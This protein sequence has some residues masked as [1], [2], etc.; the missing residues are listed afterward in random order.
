[1]LSFV[2][3]NRVRGAVLVL[4]C[5]TIAGCAV[6][7]RVQMTRAGGV[8][9][10]RVRIDYK[11]RES[12]ARFVSFGDD[13]IRLVGVPE[14]REKYS[15]ADDWFV[16]DLTVE[17]PADESRLDLARATLSIHEKDSTLPGGEPKIIRMTFD[18]P[19]QQLD[20]LL[21]DLAHSGFFESQSRPN[22]GV[23][24]KVAIDRGHNAKPWTREARLDDLA[25]RVYHEGTVTPVEQND[26]LQSRGCW[27]PS[28]ALRRAR[29]TVSSATGFLPWAR[30]PSAGRE[31]EPLPAIAR[32]R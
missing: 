19:K 9:Y 28:N 18:F 8:Q 4:I 11:L 15:T 17:Y 25:D 32:K 7:H 22:G 10:E 20:L 14:P 1:M 12:Q 3:G 5:A 21:V 27:N 31:A 16:S 6:P 23:E 26:E 2:S 13:D 30:R 24:L 29:K